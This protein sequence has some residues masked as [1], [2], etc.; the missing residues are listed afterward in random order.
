MS[1][2]S[3]VEIRRPAGRG[4]VEPTRLLLL[5][6]LVCA[7]LAGWL[8][9][10]AEAQLPDESL[11]ALAVEN[12]ETD[13]D[14]DG[15]PDGWYNVRDAKLAEGGV[16]G[17]QCLRFE[18]ELPG[19]PAR[20]SRAIGVDGQ[21][22]EAVVVG[23]WVRVKGIKPG[24]RVGERPQ[25]FMG[26][27]DDEVVTQA[28]V[29]L[30][31]WSQ[32]VLGEGWV[33]VS[34]RLPVP[35]RS[36][37]AIISVGLMG[38]TGILEVDGLS[39]EP[40]PR[41]G[42]RV[43]N[44]VLNG[45]LEW[46]DPAPAF[47][48][49][50]GPRRVMPGHE[51]DS[52]LELARAGDAATVGLG[53]PVDRF[54][55]LEVR[56]YARAS[57]LRGAGG[58]QAELIFLNDRGQVLTRARGSLPLFR[59]SG[60]FDWR[61][62][63]AVVN[64]PPDAR[65][66]VVH[67]SKVESAGTLLIDD[68]EVKAAPEASF[69]LWLP[70]HDGENPEGWF[71]YEPAPAIEAGTALDFSFLVEPPAGGLQPVRVR[72]GHLVRGEKEKE[73]EQEERAR[74]FGVSLIP[75]AAFIGEAEAKALADRLSRSGVNLARLIALD[76]P[77]TPGQSLLDGTRDDTRALDQLGRQRLSGLVDR[78]GERGI[79]VAFDLLNGRRYREGDAVAAFRDLPA[80][81]G[82]V[83][84]FSAHLRDL[85]LA[86]A[87]EWLG[88]QPTGPTSRA[89]KNNP[90]VAWITLANEISLFDLI[91]EPAML[92]PPHAEALRQAIQEQAAGKVGRRAW[93]ALEAAQWEAEAAALR[94]MGVQAPLAGSAH[95]RREPEFLAA[96]IAPG[97]D[98]V[99][100]RLFWSPPRW[101]PP[102]RRSLLWGGES[103]FRETVNHK[104]RSDRP[105]VLG[106]WGIDTGGAWALPHEAADFLLVTAMAQAGDW[107]AVVRRGIALYP[108]VW[109]SAA[110]GT[111]GGDDLGQPT[112]AINGNPAV[113]SLLPHASSI[114]LRGRT[115]GAGG[116]NSVNSS[117]PGWLT[118]ETPFTR[119]VAGWP[120]VG[121]KPVR[122]GEFD[123]ELEGEF[124]VLAVSSAGSQPLA[125]AGR[126]LVTA[127]AQSRPTDFA[128]AHSWQQEVANP[129]RGPMLMEPARGAVTWRRQGKVEAYELDAAG[130]RVKPATLESSPQA[131]RLVIDGRQGT[132]HWELVGTTD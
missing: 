53:V 94:A 13:A 22:I 65:W 122:L 28:E 39:L 128:W 66:G 130:R 102:G 61:P 40:Q 97:L 110:A 87:S 9:G 46:G 8:S 111:S 93:E 78:L 119:A 41:G 99:E 17:G 15:V 20:A 25:L 113:F 70:F 64:V 109:G 52:A 126:L 2:F 82:P 57:G 11:S 58:A 18:T 132:T 89:L 67:F 24:E 6:C 68:L 75:P 103:T 116:R 96:Q 131:V 36:K 121:Q 118:V 63:K 74:F 4:L 73:K 26:F 108:T 27:L 62:Q 34:G 45:H 125:E 72:H 85:V 92:P 55:T 29:G 47:W 127:V 88:H 104:K 76:M 1:W 115:P 5:C 7:C 129:G 91:D 86:T 100:D 77:L 117:T 60:S 32:Q 33:R 10:R 84:A 124:G 79:S 90:G 30:G 71:A 69:G 44:L 123:L 120:G 43:E 107:D 83:A 35:P 21:T 80:G 114:F 50:R 16:G 42:T 38:A 37:H 3:A 106:E 98:L 101:A 14:A 95:W 23:L 54:E 12:F 51:S 105:Y 49:T 48:E 112:N 59:W 31:P 56:L 19:R 81:G